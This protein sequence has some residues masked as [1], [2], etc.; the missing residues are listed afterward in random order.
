MKRLSL[1]KRKKG[2]R[3]GSVGAL[4]AATISKRN[5]YYFEGCELL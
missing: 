4:I 1:L 3:R 2:F 5:I